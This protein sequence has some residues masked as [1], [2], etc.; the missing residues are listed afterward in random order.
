[1]LEHGEDPVDTV[2]RE[3]AEETGYV[4]EVQQMLGVGSRTH[5][6]D[7]G[8]AGGALLHNIGLFYMVRVLSGT[9]RPETEGSTDL[10]EWVQVDVL[11]NSARAVIVDLGIDL[12]RRRPPD[13]RGMVII[14]GGLL[15]P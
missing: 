11:A 2:V 5:E 14:P 12:E 7:W 8:I 10:A 6:V 4:V 1:M 15:H 9:L 13:G 3:V